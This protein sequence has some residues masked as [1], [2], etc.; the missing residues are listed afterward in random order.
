[1]IILPKREESSDQKIPVFRILGCSEM[2]KL[3]SI[4]D[5]GNLE[6]E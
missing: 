3:M 5:I 4:S 6:D 1:M 2:R